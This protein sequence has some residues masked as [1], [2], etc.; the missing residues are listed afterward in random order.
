MCVECVWQVLFA[1]TY[2]LVSPKCKPGWQVYT[3]WTWPD[4]ASSADMHTLPRA[5]AERQLPVELRQPNHCLR[6]RVMR[7]I[8]QF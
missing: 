8:I 5:V 2:G 6:G 7:V 4:A 3:S 1:G